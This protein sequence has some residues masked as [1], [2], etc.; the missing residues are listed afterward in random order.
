[1]YDELIKTPAKDLPE[2]DLSSVIDIVKKLKKSYED[3]MDTEFG[4]LFMAVVV[5]VNMGQCRSEILDE[6]LY[7]YQ[8]MIHLTLSGLPM[9]N[10]V[11]QLALDKLKELLS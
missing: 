1:M 4:Y 11:S 2:F 9:A 6:L 7:E 5:G 8:S 10:D 3:G